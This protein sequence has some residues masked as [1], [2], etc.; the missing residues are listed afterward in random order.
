[1]MIVTKTHRRIFHMAVYVCVLCGYE[2]DPVH[3]D[4]DHGIEEGTDFV[5]LP[6]DF[7]CPL[8]G[9]SKEEFEENRDID[10]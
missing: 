7:E 10:N 8:C 2:Y 3:G 9:A 5:D 6:E 4:P 1:M